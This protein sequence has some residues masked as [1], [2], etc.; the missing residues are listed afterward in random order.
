MQIRQL[1][2]AVDGKTRGTSERRER[3]NPTQARPDH[4]RWQTHSPWPPCCRVA[5]WPLALPPGRPHEPADWLQAQAQGGNGM[6]PTLTG[7]E[8]RTPTPGRDAVLS[9][10]S[11]TTADR[12]P[13]GWANM[14]Q[15]MPQEMT[16][17]ADPSSCRSCPMAAGRVT[18][19]PQSM[20]QAR[21]LEDQARYMHGMATTVAPMVACGPGPPDGGPAAPSRAAAANPTLRLAA[22]GA[23]LATPGETSDA[24]P[25]RER[26]PSARQAET[27]VRARLTTAEEDLRKARE[28]IARYDDKSF[29]WRDPDAVEAA[30]RNFQGMD[31]RV[32]DPRTGAM[33]S[34]PSD[35]RDGPLTRAGA[36]E[37]A[38]RASARAKEL[39]TGMT[40]LRDELRRAGEAVTT[41]EGLDARDVSSR[42]M[43]ELD[44]P[45]LVQRFGPNAGLT[46]LG[47]CSRRVF[48]RW[49]LGRAF[50]GPESCAHRPCK[51]AH[52]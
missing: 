8:N 32:R 45:T 26:A 21:D 2:S 27:G 20:D 46:L 29:N 5:T 43:Q 38:R 4:S 42:R 30:Q 7:V 17:P 44:Q 23:T 49:L 24:P 31:I 51:L 34:V 41:A 47:I 37:Y 11:L 14:L 50:R 3:L 22:G 16:A 28:D 1:L 10:G 6:V 35:K 18:A 52:G 9:A 39:E 25:L 36:A 40:A 13:A 12:Q 15:K 33:V 19:L 48:D